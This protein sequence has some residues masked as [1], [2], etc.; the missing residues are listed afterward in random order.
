M[1]KWITCLVLAVL[2]GLS[3]MYYSKKGKEMADYKAKIVQIEE[4]GDPESLVAK[5]EGELNSMEGERTFSGILVTFLGAG[6]V[7]IFFVVYL[8]PFF[9]QRVTHA[10]YDSAEMVEKDVMHDA[11]SLTAQGD[12]LGAIEAYKIAAAADPLNRLP[13]VEIAKIQKMNLEDPAAAIQTIRYALESQAWEVNDAAYFLFRLAE[14]YDEIDG[15]R[16][17]AIAIMNQVID[18]FP[19]TRH[20]A[21]ARNKLHEWSVAEAAAAAEQA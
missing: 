6:L 14:L 13:W 17:S 16:E 7:G 5:M 4:T 3:W 12:Y 2:V 11:R 20:S 9:A 8:L 18:Q 21:N 19:E 1:M 10:V 15:N